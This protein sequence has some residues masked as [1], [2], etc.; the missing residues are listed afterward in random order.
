MSAAFVIGDDGTLRPA[1]FDAST[2]IDPE[3]GGVPQ[4]VNA[5]FGEGLLSSHAKGRGIGDCG[6]SQSFA[7]DGTRFRLV[8]QSEMTECRGSTRLIPTWRAE[9]R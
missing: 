6:V 1:T 2:G 7:W 8:E 4:L 3:A 9:L 5:G